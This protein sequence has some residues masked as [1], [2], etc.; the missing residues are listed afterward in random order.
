V[1]HP[2]L[3][4]FAHNF[5]IPPYPPQTIFSSSLTTTTTTITTSF[6]KFSK[7]I[8]LFRKINY[9]FMSKLRILVTVDLYCTISPHAHKKLVRRKAV[10]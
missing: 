3:H 7:P 10:F 5:H 1:R 6:K 4:P 9:P 2:K 8:G